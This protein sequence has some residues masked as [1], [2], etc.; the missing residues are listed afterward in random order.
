MTVLADECVAAV[1]ITCPTVHPPEATVGDIRML[2]LDDHKHMALVVDGPRLVTAVERGDL[3]PELSD[4]LPAR[5]V[6]ALEGRTVSPETSAL[7]AFASMRESGR[8]RLAVIDEGGG[9]V[10]LLC[11]KRSGRWFCSDRDVRSRRAA[12]AASAA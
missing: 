3:R 8:R 12:S 6:G 11:F 7:E 4:D 2:F 1:A 5:L 9:L 10:G